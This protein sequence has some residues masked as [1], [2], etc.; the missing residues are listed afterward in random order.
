MDKKSLDEIVSDLIQETIM[1]NIGENTAVLELTGDETGL[2]ADTVKETY[3]DLTNEEAEYVADKHNE[4]IKSA[5]ERR[6][7]KTFANKG[8]TPIPLWEI[9]QGE[10]NKEDIIEETER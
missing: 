5:K 1:S 4:A 9:E 2:T 3:P 6:S 8:Y 7:A 10:N